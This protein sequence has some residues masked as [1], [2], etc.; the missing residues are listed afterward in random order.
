MA[1]LHKPTTYK[2]LHVNNPFQAQDAVYR[3]LLGNAH[4]DKKLWQKIAFFSLGFFI[5]SLGVLFYAVRLQDTVPVLVGVTQWGEAQYLGEVKSS[6]V[7]EIAIQYQ[8]R[9]FITMLRTISSDRDILFRDITACY[10]MI[11]TQCEKKMT[12]ELRANDPFSL[13]L[14]Y[15]EVLPFD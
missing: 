13:G 1:S 6:Q 7:P 8:V 11:T 15:Y 12:G 9:N 2:P 3:D 5:I 10:D 4:R 14:F